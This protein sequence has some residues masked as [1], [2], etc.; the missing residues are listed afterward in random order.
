M[1]DLRPATRDDQGF[2]EEMLYTAIYV[3]DGEA[4]PPRSIVSD[5]HLSLYIE[6]FGNR[7]GDSG[8]IASTR[9]TPIGAVWVRMFTAAHPGYGFV[10]EATPELSAAVT[11]PERGRGIGTALL[12]SMLDICAARQSQ[13]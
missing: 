5:P 4:P 2:L 7:E 11:G 12:E 10:D 13:R 9:E 6:G 1:T 8:L 3:P